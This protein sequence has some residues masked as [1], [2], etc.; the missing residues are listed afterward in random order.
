[1]KLYAD[2]PGRRTTQILSDV[3][4]LCWVGLWIWAGHAAGDAIRTLR[5]PTDSLTSAGGSFQENMSGAAVSVGGLPLVGDALSAPFNALAGTGQ[6][7]AGVG[8][9][10][11]S[12]V[13][14]VAHG[15]SIVV[16]VAPILVVLAIWLFL[17]VR[18]IRRATATSRMLPLAGA[19]DLL[20]LR[21]L[22]RQPLRRL[23]TV[24]PDP[25][26]RFRTGDPEMVM[27]LA[28]LELRSTGL[29]LRRPRSPGQIAVDRSRT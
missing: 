8:A 7:L 23:A 4:M 29:T 9:S 1:M 22:T 27:R 2:L 6:Q 13:E 14:A 26:G 12:T 19:V 11:G 28:D 17:R 25:A 18:F 24:G 20:A 16:T 10:L 15:T 3:F 21:A 5:G